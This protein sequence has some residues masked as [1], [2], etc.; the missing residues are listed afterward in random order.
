MKTRQWNEFSATLTATASS[1]NV[2]FSA[3][4]NRFFLDDVVV[5]KPGVSLTATFNDYGY[6]TYC[7]EYPLDFSDVS[8][9]SAWQVT[10]VSGETITFGQVA[11]IVKG[12]TGLLLKGEAGET[13][14][15]PSSNSSTVLGDNMLIG[16]TAPTFVDAGQYF[17][18][19]GQSFVPV[20]EGTVP[21]GKALLPS[22]IIAGSGVKSL[23]F[24]FEEDDP[25]SI[26]EELGIKNEESS[27]AIYNLAGQRI[28][29]MQKGINI[30]N[31]KKV[32]K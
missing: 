20:A 12:G 6:A 28:R 26:N 32:L 17:G 14:T 30:V 24:L 1:F 25:T 19:K 9:F 29:K 13:V 2:T 10:G 21:E 22:G 23:R 18:L 5:I 16:T 4:N 31:G 3:S 8:D 27:S 7:S 15:I 11:G